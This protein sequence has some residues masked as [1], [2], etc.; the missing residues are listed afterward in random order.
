M[1]NP[2]TTTFSKNL[3]FSY[4]A[5]EQTELGGN[6]HTYVTEQFSSKKMVEEYKKLYMD[7]AAK[8]YHFAKC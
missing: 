5:T 3:E 1:Q 8:E 2:F 6:G 4:I 7:W